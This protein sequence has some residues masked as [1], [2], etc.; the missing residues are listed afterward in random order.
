MQPFCKGFYTKRKEFAPKGSKFFPVR[1]D[2]ISEGTWCAGK[3]RGSHKS[4]LPC[5]NGGEHK[6]HF[7]SP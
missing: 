5:K 4:C 7:Q 6:K 3:Q 2:P 1:V